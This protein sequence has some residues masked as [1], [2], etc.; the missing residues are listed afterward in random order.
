MEVA[1]PATHSKRIFGLDLMRVMAIIPVVMIHGAQYLK[2]TALEGFPY[3]KLY[4]GVDVFFVLSGFLIGG[5]L[6][7]IINKQNGFSADQLVSFW[8]RRWFRTLPNYY[9]V[10]LLNVLFIYLNIIKGDLEAFNYKFLFFIQNFHEPFENFFWESWSLSV[11]EWFYLITPILIFTIIKRCSPKT[12]FLAATL[13]IIALPVL[14]RYHISSPTTD[15]YSWHF[16]F[17]QTVVCRLDGIGYGLLA[18]WILYYS[19]DT[20]R[21]APLLLFLIG[22]LTLVFLIYYKVPTST[23]YKQVFYSSLYPLGIMLLIPLF[24]SY[25]LASGLWQKGVEHIS[26]ISYSMYLIN[27]GLVA[28][29]INQ[30]LRNQESDGSLVHYLLYWVMVVLFSSLIYKYFERPITGLRDKL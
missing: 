9:L 16:V 13:I 6:L 28:G 20:F 21:K 27:L 24:Y 17:R 25:K 4:D 8:K 19:P 14:Y 29:F 18:A 11:E 30:N 7:K 10:L 23:I 3:I 15:P 12:S 1:T 5:I 22:A 26:K 2:G